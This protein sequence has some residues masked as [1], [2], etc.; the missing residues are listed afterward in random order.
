LKG[1]PP[2]SAIAKP[3]SIQH[4]EGQGISLDWPESWRVDAERVMPSPLE[5]LLKPT[6]LCELLHDQPYAQVLLM[7]WDPLPP[8]TLKGA[9][10][11]T[12]HLLIV[13]TESYW[14]VTETTTV[15]NG[16]PALIKLYQ[17]PIGEPVYQYWD[18]WTQH[19]Q[20][21]WILSGWTYTSFPPE[22]QP[23]FEWILHSLRSITP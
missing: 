10:E 4:W 1:V 21:V 3:P 11:T 6:I 7:Q 12:Y 2:F 9:F 17:H 13:A 23:S 16:L 14:H 20:H 15:V 19:D 22:I 18:V 5:P 8:V